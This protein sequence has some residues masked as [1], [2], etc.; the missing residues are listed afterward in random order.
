MD[1]G[2]RARVELL[3]KAFERFETFCGLLDI[4]PKDGRRRKFQLNQIQRLF[5]ID[6]SGRDIVLKPRQIGFTTLEQARDI[7]HF[8]TFP[9]AR[10]VTTCQSLQDN[11]PLRLLSNNYRV[12]FEGL[13]RAG[14]ALKFR[15]ESSTEWALADRDATLRIVVAGASE[16]SASKKGRAG[17]ISRLH[18]T[19]T[20]FYEFADA[21][22]NALN[23][24]VPGREFGSEIVNESTPNGAAG[25]Y[26]NQCQIAKASKGAYKFH[27]YP[28][29]QQSE[30]RT[31]LEPGTTFVVD[32]D[33]EREREL[34]ALGLT[35]EQLLWYRNKVLEKG[36][37]KTDQEYPTDPETCFLV[38]GRSFFSQRVTTALIAKAPR[39]PIESRKS[40]QIRI[41]EKPIAGQEYV[42]SLDCSEGVGGDPSGGL[43]YHRQSGR[44]VATLDGQFQPYDAAEV[45]AALCKEYNGALFVVER[46]NHG[47][48]VLVALKDPRINYPRV[49]RHE[50]DKRGWPTNVVTRPVMLDALEDAHR[51]GL[52]TSPDVHLLGQMRKFIINDQGKPEAAAGEH[53][54]MVIAAAIG[55]MVRQRKSV[56]GNLTH[57]VAAAI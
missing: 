39:G 13:Q 28:W 23:E 43:M 9:G 31:A 3:R 52:W 14:V 56:R 45:G 50:D 36:Q 44:H 34:A 48:A 38:S 33:N 51:N 2:D 54:D 40:G 26:Y 4:V 1:G 16:A 42:F 29:Y 12:M 49:Y 21:T 25:F 15:T 37:D 24:C 5:C 20:A 10:V 17:T 22:L 46:N 18:L 53:D 8:L 30:Y 7:W 19:E 32:Q 47:H 41:Y 35:P 55:W 57:D 27:F 6:R 11:S